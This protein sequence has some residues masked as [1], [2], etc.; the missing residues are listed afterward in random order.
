MI[1]NTFALIYQ[2]YWRPYLQWEQNS[3]QLLNETFILLA[4][5]FNLLYTDYLPDRGVRYL[6]GW[7]NISLIGIM[8]GVNLLYLV[9]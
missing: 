9:V 3:L 5:Y 2:G 8:I 4:S 7:V 6:L 1:C